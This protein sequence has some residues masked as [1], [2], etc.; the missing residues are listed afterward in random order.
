MFVSEGLGLIH[1]V[2]ECLYQVPGLIHQVLKCLCQVARVNVP[3]GGVFV[4]GGLGLMYQVVE[5]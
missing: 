1:Q 4:S 3:G 5:G 2:V